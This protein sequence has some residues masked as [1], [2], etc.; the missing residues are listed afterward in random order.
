MDVVT[1]P[2]DVKAPVERLT[3]KGSK[4]DPDPS[5][6]IRRS[7]R[8]RRAL[9]PLHPV[10]KLK[11]PTAANASAQ[12]PRRDGQAHTRRVYKLS[13][14]A[15]RQS[16]EW[17]P[18]A[19]N[20]KA[21]STDA[22]GAWTALTASNVHAHGVESREMPRLHVFEFEDLPWFPKKLRRFM[23]D[24]LSFMA[25]LSARPFEA[26]AGKLA[27]GLRATQQSHL[28]DLCS[29]AGGPALQTTRIL[30][31]RFG[32]P[33]GLML[34]D[35]FP[36]VEGFRALAT[37]FPYVEYASG[38]VSA[39]QVP[40]TLLGFRVMFNGFHHFQ[41]MDARRILRDAVESGRGIA[42]FELVGRSP[43]GFLQVALTPLTLWVLTPWIRP[44]SLSRLFLTYVLPAIPFFVL[45][46]GLV[47]CLRVYSQSEMEALIRPIAPPHYHWETGRVR[48]APFPGAWASYFLG[49]PIGVSED[50]SD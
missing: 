41:P 5:T 42:V 37:E 8:V 26:F 34:T 31:Q 2:S 15:Q 27:Q 36:D 38:P 33:A 16:G 25:R 13:N 23:I 1:R 3:A 14:S 44:F 50:A 47:S 21:C 28:L 18:A 4:N 40:K 39:T 49:Y 46:D 45:W 12:I 19:S 7:S 30:R 11:D 6:A 29:G 22:S 24:Y 35:L 43:T 9:N 48:T 10:I 32:L 17:D 20:M